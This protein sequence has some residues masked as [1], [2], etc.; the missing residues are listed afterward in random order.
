[1]MYINK[2]LISILLL[3]VS[4]LLGASLYFGLSDKADYI[5][6]LGM[7]FI[8]IPSGSFEMGACIESKEDAFLGVSHC[9]RPDEN[10][11]KSETP[12]HFV[13][14]KSYQMG[15]YEV[16]L[17]QF[18]AFIKATGNKQLVDD[19]FM[20]HNSAG[21]DAPVQWVNWYDAQA[22]ITW[23]NKNKPAEDAG[24]YRLPSESEWEYSCKAGEQSRYC[25]GNDPGV[26]A[27]YIDN[28]GGVMHQVGT[29]KQNAFGLYDMNGNVSEWVEDCW[30]DNY[31]GA[32]LDN[33]AWVGD[34]CLEHIQRGGSIG[35]TLNDLRAV[36]R[37]G[38][39][40]AERRFNSGFRVVR[41]S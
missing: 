10:A 20:S 5:N 6:F 28:S 38:N 1:M 30:H 21:D 3:S 27:W 19:N 39:A 14:I 31:Q 4:L 22:F 25:G 11:D 16:T 24:I 29:K 17:R 12:R 8:S 32:P 23:L 2:K 13:S 37:V 33:K 35:F 34:G 18:K 40:S 26:V 36:G 15:K 7:K 9:S 41:E